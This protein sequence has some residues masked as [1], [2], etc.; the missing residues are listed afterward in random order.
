MASIQYIDEPNLIVPLAA[1]YNTRGNSGFVHTL[2]NAKDQRKLNSVY[3]PIQNKAT[4]KTT[5]YL[6][7][8]PGVIDSVSTYGTSTRIPYLWEIGSGESGDAPTNRWLFSVDGANGQNTA[9]SATTTVTVTTR[10]FFVPAYVDKTSISGVDTIVLQLQRISAAAVQLTFYATS[11]AAWTEITD[12]DFPGQIGSATG[13][14]EFL[15]GYAFIATSTN[16]IA[17]SQLNSLSDWRANGFIRRRSKQDQGTGLARLGGQIISFGSA[18]MEVYKNAGTASGSPL[19][20]VAEFD[21]GLAAP[22][23]DQRHYS[24]VLD[25]WLYWVGQNP[26]GVF[27]FNSQTVEKV[28]TPAIDKIFA[29][30]PI[31]FVGALSFQG[32]RA[33]AI[34]LTTTQQSPSRT[35]LFFPEWEDWFDWTSTVFTPQSSPRRMDVCLGMSGASANKLFQIATSTEVWRDDGTDYTMTHQFKMPNTGN[36]HRRL[37]MFGVKGDTAASTTTSTLKV[38][39]STDDWQTSSAARDIDMT[40]AKKHIYRCGGYS[41]LGVYLDHTGNLDCRMEAV[42]A[43]VE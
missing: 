20:A 21:Y 34:G 10:S 14:M 32:K 39:F 33:I 42:V 26:T 17:N 30:R 23:A 41:D 25:G 36:A 43:R 8:R 24:A 40:K 15:D 3:E 38:R 9:S 6:A 12:S 35:L 37:L 22:I 7:K 13:K 2:V 5:L 29:G 16:T 1:S 31:Y 28:S 18:S 11:V 19:E 27:A 4:G